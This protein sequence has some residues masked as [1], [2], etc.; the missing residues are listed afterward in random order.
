M[1]LDLRS[2]WCC[3][4][5]LFNAYLRGFPID[6]TRSSVPS[7]SI[8][9]TIS[10]IPCSFLVPWRRPSLVSQV[11]PHPLLCLVP[12][13][14]SPS[15]SP[16]SVLFVSFLSYIC[17]GCLNY[18]INTVTNYVF[19]E[20]T[21]DCHAIGIAFNSPIHCYYIIENMVQVKLNVLT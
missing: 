7:S 6:R 15:P 2:Q 17:S 16:A 9:W 3:T 19:W 20:D 14:L 11:P 1:G 13:H 5:L 4:G 8:H 21:I 18:F 12:S 10:A